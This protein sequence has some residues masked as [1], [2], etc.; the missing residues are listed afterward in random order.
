MTSGQSRMTRTLAAL[1]LATTV[2][3][4]AAHAQAQAASSAAAPA[5]VDPKRLEIAQRVAGELMP[6]GTY[7]TMMKTVLD[8]MTG[9]IMNQMLNMPIRD[10]AKIGGLSED[11]LAKVGPATIRQVAVIMDP[12][13]EQR[14]T[15]LTKVMMNEIGEFMSGME[16]EYRAGLADGLA[17][18]FSLEQLSELQRFF[19]TPTGS[20]YASQSMLLYANPAM[21]QRMQ[22]MMPKLMQAMPGIMQKVQAATAALPKPRDAKDLTPAERKQIEDLLG[23]SRGT[24]Q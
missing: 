15:V 1:A 24:Q 8:Q 17:A 5:S 9:N 14:T 16:P 11:D 7:R 3:A 21:M 18:S 2:I 19:A 13:F 20:A 23:P 6:V 4:P 22:T 10:F 12:A